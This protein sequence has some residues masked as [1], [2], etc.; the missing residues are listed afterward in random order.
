MPVILI[1]TPKKLCIFALQ[2]YGAYVPFSEIMQENFRIMGA[3]F[4]NGP[5]VPR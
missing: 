3:I 5:D 2:H 1:S 4:K